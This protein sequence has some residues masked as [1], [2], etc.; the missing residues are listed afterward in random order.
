MTVR[1]VFARLR[2]PPALVLVAVVPA[3]VLACGFCANLNGNPLALPHPKAIEIAVATRAAIEKDHLNPKRL[4]PNEVLF[5]GG[6][7]TTALHKLPAP[8]LVKAWAR[9]CRCPSKN[10]SPWNAQFVF[11][12][13]EE[14]CGLTVRA[15]G[16]WFETGPFPHNDARLVTTRT[17]FG[18]LF[19]GNL[20]LQEARE[21]GLVY[22]EGDA[23]AASLL[24]G[25]E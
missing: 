15:G 20:T 4:V 16:V 18:A 8:L 25:A 19:M 7:G 5:E 2:W 13:T 14:T 1:S 3:P 6:W 9:K 10:G 11:I 17:T 21:R 24:P 23:R 22:L 12:D